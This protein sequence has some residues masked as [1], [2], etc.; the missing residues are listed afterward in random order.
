MIW[1]LLFTVITALH[2]KNELAFNQAELQWR[3]CQITPEQTVKKLNLDIDKR[4]ERTVFLWDTKS[5]DLISRNWTVRMRKTSKDYSLS[6]KKNF[7]IYHVDPPP[8]S[9]CELDVKES[10]QKVG[11]SIK[12][13]LNSLSLPANIMDVLKDD[14]SISPYLKAAKWWGKATSLNLEL[15]PDGEEDSIEIER[16]S[17]SEYD[18]TEF[19]VR[20]PVDRVSGAWNYWSKRLQNS[21]ITLCP[22]DRDLGALSLLRAFTQH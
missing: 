5:G 21:G 17:F 22:M 13:K 19:S 3:L 20:V 11:C 16:V 8:G 15:I 10:G 1:S 7:P 14:P 18:R 2:A 9:E 6:V 12:E 4:K